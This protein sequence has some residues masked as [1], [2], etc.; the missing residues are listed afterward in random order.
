MS[1]KL[2]TPSEKKFVRKAM[3]YFG[4]KALRFSWDSSTKTYPDIWVNLNGMP[5]ITVTQEWIRQP[6]GEKSKRITHELIHVF[7]KGHDEKIGYSTFPDK[8][9]FSKKVYDDIIK[10]G[11]KYRSI[12]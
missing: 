7:G 12:K 9:T 5:V 10:G 3:R 2:L 8:D 6:S 11:N 4:I 1:K